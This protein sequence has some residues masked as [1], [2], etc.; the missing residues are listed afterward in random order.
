MP[1]LSAVPY[2]RL[3][4]L[5]LV[6][7]VLAATIAFGFA[8]ASANGRA[9]V[10]ANHEQG[11]YRVEVA[12]VPSRPVV[13]NTHLSVRL[14]PLGSE[15]PLTR[16]RVQVSA[17]GP[18]NSGGFGPLVADNNVLPQFFETTLPFAEPGPWR[19]SISVAT[20]LGQ[21][22]ILVPMEVR[23]REPINLIL[24]AAI[25]VAVAALVIWTYDRLRS[26]RRRRTLS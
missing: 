24:L 26:R 9:T 11:P 19:V 23:A 13:N 1:L 3:R 6:F 18:A 12:I 21:E 16:A 25:A 22:T 2:C 15:S 5:A 20:D 7:L 8:P 4:R 10:I 17:A 14:F